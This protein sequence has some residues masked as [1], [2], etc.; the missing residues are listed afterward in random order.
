[1]AIDPVLDMPAP[2]SLIL[3][4]DITN[5]CNLDCI[6]CSLIDNRKAF[7]EPAAAMKLEVF[8]KIAEE[9]FPYLSEIA[10]SCEAEPILHPQFIRIMKIIAEKTERGTRPP[11]RMTTN[12]TLL[13]KERLDAIFDAGIFGLSISIDGFAAETFS[14]LRKNGEISKVFEALDEIVRRKTAAGLQGPD[15]PRLQINYTLMKSNLHELIPLIEYSR[16][17]GLENFTVTHVYSTTSKDMTYESM[18]SMPE[19]SDRVLIEAE[20][21]CR[22]YGIVAR[23]PPLFRPPAPV[24]ATA[25]VS[26]S[27]FWQQLA[28]HFRAP[29]AAAVPPPPATSDLSCGAPWSMLKIR[30]D[31]SVHPCDLWNAMTPLGTLQTQSFHEIWMSPKYVELRAGLF[32]GSPTLAHCLKCSRISQDNLEKRK[33]QSPLAH[34]SIP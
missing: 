13:T 21:K 17:W 3:R 28:D 7:S 6:G 15:L 30:W 5:T 4:M 11:V 34:T 16:R 12:A 32:S 10:L 9:V 2:H 18:A 33:I 24:A 29:V 27:G 23:F 25:A 14:K 31:G 20:K 8:E 22:E 1:M 26:K 19:E